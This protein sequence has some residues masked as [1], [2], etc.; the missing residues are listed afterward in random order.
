MKLVS[1]I[2][3]PFMLDEVRDALLGLGV[4]G[5]TVSE[6]RGFGAQRGRTDVQREEG[7]AA[8]YLPKLKIY[9]ATSDDAADKVVEAIA[10]AARTGTIGDGKIFVFSLEQVMRIRTGERGQDAL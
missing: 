7:Y 6:V 9:V 5:V 2:I 1:A 10:K 8:S 3:K 4:Q